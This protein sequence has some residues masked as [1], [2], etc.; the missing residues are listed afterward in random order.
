MKKTALKL[1]AIPFL[2]A[3]SHAQAAICPDPNNSSLQWGEIPPPWEVSPFSQN[4]PQGEINTRFVRANILVAGFGRGIA[5]NYQNSIGYY[6]IWW[7]VNV[8][9]PS[10]NDNN[11]RDSLAGYECTSSLAE[12]VF[13]PG[14]PGS[15]L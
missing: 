7:Q 12:C 1:A 11:W 5:C 10:R 3:V 4:R 14:S 6:T 8:K 2:L 9:M 13:Y 15:S